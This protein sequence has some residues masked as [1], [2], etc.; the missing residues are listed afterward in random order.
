MSELRE[1]WREPF[2]WL[3]EEWRDSCRPWSDWRDGFLERLDVSD[4]SDDDEVVE[5]FRRID[6]D[7]SSDDDRFRALTVPDKRAEVFP[8]LYEDDEADAVA[9][10]DNSKIP[11]YWDGE[12][13]LK[14]SD[15]ADAWVPMG[16]DDVPAEEPVADES[17]DDVV[18]DV[19]TVIAAPALAEVTRLVPDVA[20]MRPELLRALV[21][22]VVVERLVA[23]D[24]RD[25]E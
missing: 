6:E 9:P 7:L 18:A 21:S 8:E 13:W 10:V 23:A 15:D 17:V 5:L 2:A 14:W 19:V 20:R 4:V 25:G 16:G 11:P 1:K 3:A 22:E 12:R 24:R